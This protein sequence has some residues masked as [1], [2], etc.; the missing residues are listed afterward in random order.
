MEKKNLIYSNI[1]SVYM[2]V[3]NLPNSI[4]IMV[5][6][7]IVITFINNTLLWNIINLFGF[8]RQNIYCYNPY[9]NTLELCD[10]MKLCSINKTQDITYLIYDN[11]YYDNNI[12][13]TSIEYF[14]MNSSRNYT[15]TNITSDDPKNFLNPHTFDCNALYL[16]NTS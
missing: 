1:D 14:S 16:S 15:I 7:L 5:V 9:S 2:N 3:K 13:N 10:K 8:Y 11:D 12:S 4:L 6:I